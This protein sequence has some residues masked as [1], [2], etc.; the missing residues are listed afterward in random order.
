MK[1]VVQ[2]GNYLITETEIGIRITDVS[3]DGIMA[4]V[5]KSSN[6]IEVYDK[7]HPREKKTEKEE[8]PI[9]SIFQQALK[10]ASKKVVSPKSEEYE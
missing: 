3:N 8:S 2:I 5:P 4:I 9:G 1:N 10:E 7:W 6:T